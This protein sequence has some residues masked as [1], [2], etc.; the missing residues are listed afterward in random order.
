VSSDALAASREPWAS[1]RLSIVGITLAPRVTP[2]VPAMEVKP[3]IVLAAPVP[4]S[5]VLPRPAQDVVLPDSAP[6]QV[7]VDALAAHLAVFPAARLSFSTLPAGR[8][9]NGVQSP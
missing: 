6:P 5:M 7:V 9:R 4:V 8:S 3:V 2:L 1:S